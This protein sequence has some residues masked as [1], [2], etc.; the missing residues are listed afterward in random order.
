MALTVFAQSTPTVQVDTWAALKALTIPAIP[1]KMTV[2][3]KG[4]TSA[5][6]G[7]GGPF[8][9]TASTITDDGGTVAAPNAGAGSWLRDYS[10]PLN[11]KWFGAVGNGVAD[12]T[13]A[14]QSI[15]LANGVTT[16]GCEIF[17]PRGNYLISKLT[18]T[19]VRVDLTMEGGGGEWYPGTPSGLNAVT[20]FTSHVNSTNII[21][22]NMSNH[23]NGAIA[24]RW[25]I[26]RNVAI[27]GDSTKGSQVG[28]YIANRGVRTDNLIVVNCGSH[29]VQLADSVGSVFNNAIVG[30]NG[31]DGFNVDGLFLPVN[32]TYNFVNNAVIYF[33]TG[34][35]INVVHGTAAMGGDNLAIQNNTGLGIKLQGS[36]GVN[37]AFG[38]IF[39][40]VYDEANTGGSVQF[41]AGSRYNYVGFI[42]WSS[43]APSDAGIDNGWSGVDINL[44]SQG[45]IEVRPRVQV[46]SSLMV[47]TTTETYK[48]QIRDNT[49]TAGE[50]P[51]WLEAFKRQNSDTDVGLLGNDANNNFKMAV[52]GSGNVEF[53]RYTGGVW[54]EFF[55]TSPSGLNLDSLYVDWMEQSAP[56]VSATGHA[57]V[58]AD[59]TSH[60]LKASLNNGAYVDIATGGGSISGLTANTIPVATSATAIGNGYEQLGNNYHVPLTNG[61]VVFGSSTNKYKQ[62]WF[63]GSTETSS[64]PIITEN[65]TWNSGGVTF[66]GHL[67]NITDTASAVGSLFQDWQ[68]A[69]VSK[70]SIDKTGIMIVA[71]RMDANSYR[72]MVGGNAYLRV[73]ATPAGLEMVSGASILWASSATVSSTGVD[74]SA[75]RSAAGEVAIGTGAQGSTAGTLNTTTLKLQG[76]ASIYNGITTVSGGIPS[77]LATVDLTAQSAA[78]TATTIYTPAASQMFRI[79]FV[80]NVT[81]AAT[82]SSILGGTTGVVLTYTEPDGSVAQTVTVGMF[83]QNGTVITVASGN[84]GNSTTTLSHG[85]AIIYAKTGVAIQYAVGYTSVGGTAMQ[86]SVHAKCEAL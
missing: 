29:G 32:E 27:V 41:T 25:S 19:D 39:E 80:I 62:G 65:Q 76:K 10:G 78:I 40:R 36:G 75:S 1:T 85:D 83:A 20:F 69:G 8:Y 54:T 61:V 48:S 13:A 59:S 21:T 71:S 5:D 12:D 81:T 63:G 68:V 17:F 86:Y 77:E 74:T 57:R 11:A 51:N 79:S 82:T 84:T 46:N 22:Y 50:T 34:N 4:R 23:T 6:D 28:L 30:F 7:G 49:T 58:Y 53:G 16:N 47:G 35:G 31:G 26:L 38:C 43:T 67:I 52:A 64:N 72:S 55:N 56:S 33:N 66:T 37:P 60:T 44:L 42:R 70:A 3:M 24:G 15:P 45:F 2:L 9:Y 18:F 14:I 73:G